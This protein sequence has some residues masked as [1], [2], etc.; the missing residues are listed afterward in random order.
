M[1]FTITTTKEVAEAI[2]NQCEFEAKFS[3]N[4]SYELG[5]IIHNDTYSVVQIKAIN[6]KKIEAEDVFWLGHHSATNKKRE[7]N[8]STHKTT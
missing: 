3:S 6:G 4:R 1:Y 7:Y 2:K 8:G 5:D